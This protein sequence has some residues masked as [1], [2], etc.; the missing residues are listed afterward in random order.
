MES[1]SKA[2]TLSRVRNR[3]TSRSRVART[4]VTVG[5]R[6]GF[7]VF[8]AAAALAVAVAAG[9]ARDG[10]SVGG[11]RSIPHAATFGASTRP[12]GWAGELAYVSGGKLAVIDH[13][14][15]RRT[16]D[17]PSAGVP[18][19]PSWSPDGR[20][21]A[22]FQLPAATAAYGP[23]G[24]L[25]VV[26]ADGGDAH[27]LGSATQFAWDPRRDTLAYLHDGQVSLASM[28]SAP[29]TVPPM[30]AKG[31]AENVS[32]SPSGRDLIVSTVAHSAAGGVG[33]LVLLVIGSHR[34]RVVATSHAYAFD[35]AG[36][37]PDGK[38][39]LYWKD[40]DFSASIAAD[41]LP[42]VSRELSSGRTLTLATMLRYP[43]WLAWAPSGGT[44]AIVAGADRVVWD[45]A[46]HVALCQ[47][48][49][50]TCRTEPQPKGSTSIDPAWS[51][52]GQLY[53][54]RST[55]TPAY[56]MGPPP[57]V[58]G[59][60]T[61]EPFGWHAVEAWAAAGAVETVRVQRGE[62]QPAGLPGGAGGQ[63]PTPAGANLLLVRSGELWLLHAGSSVPTR[64]S[65]GLGPYG[66]ADPGYYGYIDWHEA[67]SWHA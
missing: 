57:K 65:G 25:W 11:G 21:L 15:A 12:V 49:S 20:W 18:S 33:R 55:G 2:D 35:L 36:W 58:P 66:P 64:I 24:T 62:P 4:F 9:A 48:A 40:Q 19:Q 7:S 28:G 37:W 10:S 61:N 44:V 1:G 5:Y 56:S 54:A 16:V 29:A 47:V 3:P 30:G 38:G 60:P 27:A 59:I 42:L 41:G 26:R 39:L 14:G 31:I 43:D 50:G 45:G 22:F 17:V 52:L 8:V 34:V 51:D 13:A 32:W 63:A 46:K 6:A 53:F 67:F 23:P